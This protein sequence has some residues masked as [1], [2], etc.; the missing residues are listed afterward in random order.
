MSGEEGNRSAGK[1][2]WLDCRAARGERTIL[3]T[4][5]LCSAAILAGEEQALLGNSLSQ[6]KESSTNE[7]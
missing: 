1:I 4:V 7:L 3:L 5:A 2:R 6:S